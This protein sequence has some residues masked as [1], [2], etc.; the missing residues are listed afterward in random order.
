MFTG[1]D[2]LL[3]RH[4]V[5]KC[6]LKR[7]RSGGRYHR[8]LVSKRGVDMSSDFAVAFSL[9][10]CETMKAWLEPRNRVTIGGAA[11]MSRAESF[12]LS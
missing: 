8:V 10:Q 12:S 3:I 9:M 6:S 1:Y 7:S 5:R 2:R 4:A 11:S